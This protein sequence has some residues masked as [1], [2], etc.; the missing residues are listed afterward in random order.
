MS[1]SAIEN[2]EELMGQNGID[3]NEV[4]KGID[5]LTASPSECKRNRSEDSSMFEYSEDSL[6]DESFEDSLIDEDSLEKYESDEYDRDVMTRCSTPMQHPIIRDS[7]AEDY[8]DFI[9]CMDNSF[10]AECIPMLPSV[11]SGNSLFPK[12]KMLWLN[13]SAAMNITSSFFE[14]ETTSPSG[15]LDSS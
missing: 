14:D 1:F 9:S 13:Y 4:I 8:D 15:I 11:I 12:V 2:I 7:Y 10:H 5:G 6:F 3:I